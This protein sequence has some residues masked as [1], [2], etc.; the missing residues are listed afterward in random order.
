MRENGFDR[1]DVIADRHE[2]TLR[3][4]HGASIRNHFILDST[5]LDGRLLPETLP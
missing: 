3:C 2:E 5:T 1:I 4:M